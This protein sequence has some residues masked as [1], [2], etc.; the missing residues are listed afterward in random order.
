MLALHLSSLRNEVPTT[1]L[2]AGWQTSVH[3]VRDLDSPCDVESLQVTEALGRGRM[4]AL[5]Q[6][7]EDPAVRAWLLQEADLTDVP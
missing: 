4:L 5:A 2:S 7:V 1:D 3:W 6:Q